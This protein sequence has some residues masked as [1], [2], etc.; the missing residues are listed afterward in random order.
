MNDL[1]EWTIGQV[2]ERAG[3]ATS[4]IRYYESIGLVR[5]PKRIADLMA[6]LDG[7]GGMTESMRSLS[8]RKLP[9]ITAQMKRAEAMSEWLHVASG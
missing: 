2:A 3:V 1:P 7:N 4:A 6:G 5:E 9:A 8:A